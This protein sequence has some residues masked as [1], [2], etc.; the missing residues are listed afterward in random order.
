MCT[1]ALGIG[2]Q[3]WLCQSGRPVRR[4]SGDCSGKEARGD[5]GDLH[6]HLES[7]GVLVLSVQCVDECS[8]VQ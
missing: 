3:S 6:L 8:L 4:Q 1:D 2:H 7:P 5:S